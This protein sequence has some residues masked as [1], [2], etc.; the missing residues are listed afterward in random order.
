M[1][2]QNSELYEFP[3]VSPRTSDKAPRG[4]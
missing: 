1:A 3:Q 4:G 2:A